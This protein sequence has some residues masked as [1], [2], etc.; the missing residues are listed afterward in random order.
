MLVEEF[1]RRFM[2]H[3]L[4]SGFYKIRYYGLLA[5]ANGAVSQYCTLLPSSF[6]SFIE[7]VPGAK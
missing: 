3:V 1:I 2:Q 5:L 4:P 6:I 7:I